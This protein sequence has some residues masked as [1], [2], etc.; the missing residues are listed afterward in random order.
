MECSHFMA[1]L[2][3]GLFKA[4]CT[5]LGTNFMENL[6]VNVLLLG[7]VDVKIKNLKGDVFCKIEV[8]KEEC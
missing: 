6:V 4:S 8:H 7:L 2:H 5:F 1:S 3:F